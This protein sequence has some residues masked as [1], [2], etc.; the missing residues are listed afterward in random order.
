M[1]RN[2]P[3]YLKQAILICQEKIR[4]LEEQLMAVMSKLKAKGHANESINEQS[5]KHNIE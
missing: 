1:T 3:E 2:D 5:L 4:E